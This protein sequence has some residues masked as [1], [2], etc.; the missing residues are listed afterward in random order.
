MTSTD[1]CHMSHS[2]LEVQKHQDD[3]SFRQTMAAMRASA[4]PALSSQIKVNQAATDRTVTDIAAP[5]TSATCNSSQIKV[6]QANN[7]N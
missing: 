2:S 4:S 5:L 6:N 3:L 7:T 1:L